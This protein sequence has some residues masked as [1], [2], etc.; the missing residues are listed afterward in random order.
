MAAKSFRF[1]DFLI[2]FLVALVLVFATY[3]PSRYSLYHWFIQTPD[4][5]DPLLAFA[6][7]V[8]LIGWVVYLRATVRSLGVIGTLLAFAFFATLTWL[9]IDYNILSVENIKVLTYVV[10]VMLAAIIATG[11]S[12]SHIRRRMS[13]QLDVDEVDGD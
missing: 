7:V 12:W 5:L 10:L 2:R 4:K 6:A 11:M 1:T 8:V 9:M 3:N 13:G